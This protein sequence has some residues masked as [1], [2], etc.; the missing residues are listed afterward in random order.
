MDMGLDNF[1]PHKLIIDEGEYVLL[2][3]ELE[4]VKAELDAIKEEY[5]QI[6]NIYV[7][8]KLGMD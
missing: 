1:T 5:E 3:E 7:Y 2:V 8:G 4:S 6:K